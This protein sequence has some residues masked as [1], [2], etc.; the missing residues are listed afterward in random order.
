MSER[1][2]TP[3]EMLERWYG[4]ECKCD[5]GVGFLCESCHDTQVLRDLIAENQRLRDLLER[6][7][8]DEDDETDN[9]L[10]ASLMTETLIE[11]GP[12][13]GEVRDE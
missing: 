13:V 8:A 2:Q 3:Q 5:P 9:D 1:L 7:V 11:L 4:V 6:W 12:T 10:D